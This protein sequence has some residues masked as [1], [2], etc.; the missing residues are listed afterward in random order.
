MKYIDLIVATRNRREKLLKMLDSVP[1]G[2]VGNVCINIKIACDGDRDTYEYIKLMTDYSVLLFPVQMGSVFCRN[3][4]CLTVNDGL[5]YATDDI[6]FEPGSIET[7]F[8]MFNE[9]FTGKFEDDGVVGFVQNGSF[10]PTGVA[11][12]GQKFLQRY[13]GKQLFFPE[14][15]HFAA[16]EIFDHAE[17]LGRF[18]QCKDARV[19]HYHPC[20]MK[21]QMDQTHADARIHKANDMKL[22][23]DRRSKGLIWGYN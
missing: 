2:P 21:D 6:V 17:R 20:L 15:F 23:D 1:K 8:K 18:V 5:L 7:A 16:Q 3:T 22:K 13:K 11:L 4:L 10:H 12:V 9:A 14:Y 19:F